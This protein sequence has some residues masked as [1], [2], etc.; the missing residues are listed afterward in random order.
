MISKF[1]KGKSQHKTSHK[2]ETLE[3]A[4][5]IPKPAKIRKERPYRFFR[6][7]GIAFVAVRRGDSTVLQTWNESTQSPNTGVAVTKEKVIPAAKAIAKIVLAERDLESL[8][9]KP[10]GE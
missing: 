8:G 5:V 3:A 4:P 10:E 9:V 2:K 7:R 1:G 6:Y